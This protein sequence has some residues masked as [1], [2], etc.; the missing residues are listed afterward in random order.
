RLSH[1]AGEKGT[2]AELRAALA[3]HANAGAL[4]QVRGFDL[5]L[6]GDADGARAAYAR[7]LELA[8]DDAKALAGMGRVL[9]EQEPDQA[10][11]FF[12]RAVLADPDD[13]EPELDAARVVLAT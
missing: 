2:P 6:S 9:R 11:S 3:K 12:D 13:P 8:P 4:Q 1:Q 7:A 5:E 10:V